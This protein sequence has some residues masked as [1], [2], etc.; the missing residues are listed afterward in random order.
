LS[1]ETLAKLHVA[2]MV[3][4]VLVTP[5]TMKFPESVLWVAFMSQYANFVGHFA[6]YDGAR[7][8]RELMNEIKELRAE[9]RRLA[10]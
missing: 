4:W 6:S 1:P 8:E 5:V 2:A 10:A 7:G 3:F 9:V